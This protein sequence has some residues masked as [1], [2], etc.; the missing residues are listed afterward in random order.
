MSV[1]AVRRVTV[2]MSTNQDGV[3]GELQVATD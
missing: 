3:P 2:T 1:G